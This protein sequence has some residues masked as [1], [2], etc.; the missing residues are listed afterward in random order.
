MAVSSLAG[1]LPQN[2]VGTA[3]VVIESILLLLVLVS[4]GLRLWSR[5]L[6]EMRLEANDYLILIAAVSSPSV[7]PRHHYTY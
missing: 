4:V 1:S 3:T 6:L 7:K 5:R 2:T